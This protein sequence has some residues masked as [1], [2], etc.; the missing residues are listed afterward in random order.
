[1]THCTTLTKIH[2]VGKKQYK[3][4]SVNWYTPTAC[5][6]KYLCFSPKDAGNSNLLID[7]VLTE[8]ISSY[9]IWICGQSLCHIKHSHKEAGRFLIITM[10]IHRDWELSIG[11]RVHRPME[12]IGDMDIMRN[13]R[14]V[15]HLFSFWHKGKYDPWINKGQKDWSK[16]LTFCHNLHSTSFSLR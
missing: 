14:P 7:L 15:E 6:Y 10:A 11:G 5:W 8:I 12:T 9:G 13:H 4:C 2:A 3:T 1:M 16:H